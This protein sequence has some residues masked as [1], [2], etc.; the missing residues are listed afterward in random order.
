MNKIIFLLVVLIFLTACVREQAT[1]DMPKK[2]R[3]PAVAGQFYPFESG[4]ISD[5]IQRFLK[6]IPP[7]KIAGQVRALIVPHAGYDYSGP[8]AAWAFKA[9]QG[10]KI[11]TAVMIGNSHQAYFD[12]AAVDDSDFWQTPLGEVAVDRE[13]ADKLVAAG[14]GAIKFDGAPHQTD[15]NL[16]VQLPFLQSVLA[17]EFKIVPIE[18][19]NKDDGAYK[20]LAQALKDNLDESDLVVVSTD[21][22]HY[23]KYADANKIDT[24]TLEKIKTGKAAELEKYLAEAENAGYVNE[25]TALCGADAVKTAMELS[26]LADWEEIEI[27]KY[28]N[29]G[30]VPGIGDKSQVVGYGAVAF[31]QS[32][33]SKVESQ[34]ASATSSAA[35]ANGELNKEQQETL[36]K[37]ARETVEVYVKTGEV[38]EF[39]V[40]DIRLN[41]KQ[42]AFVTLD[43]NGQLRG[44]IGQ[45][46]PSDEP[47]WRVVRDMAVAACSEDGRF[48]PV[49]KDE[50]DKLE[51][52][53]SVLSAPERI[54]DWRKIELGKH[55]V[56]I[57]QGGRSGVFLPQVAADT[58]WPLEE[59]LSQL[60]WQKAGLPPDCY[61]DKDT[62]I[63]VF[64]AQVFE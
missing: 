38:P 27:L 34:N 22:S 47:L 52:E 1:S 35:V 43:K 10:K 53:V 60:C 32:L 46:V 56:I 15:H 11:R 13:L 55:G 25:Q 54:D 61:K 37:I 26:N 57:R 28:M 24:A 63:L 6:D 21:M 17:G 51:Y 20:K 23:P 7:R 12:G 39:N 30:D 44:C 4:A 36:L 3:E 42:G 18:F 5:K 50:L 41:Q 16:E 2:I 48:A 62:E 64:T 49:S 14:G 33:K 59:F 29:S 9:L 8:V 58:G 40:R 31:F 19:G 45:I